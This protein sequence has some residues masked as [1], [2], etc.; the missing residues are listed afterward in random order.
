MHA[1]IENNVIT[2]LRVA[3]AGGA[4]ED[5]EWLDFTDP[6]VRSGPVM[7]TG[8]RRIL[9]NAADR[10]LATRHAEAWYVATVLATAAASWA[11]LTIARALTAA[12]KETP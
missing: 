11:L 7:A 8:V 3:P 2:A 12:T 1:L 5:G 10:A 4:W 6:T 9:N